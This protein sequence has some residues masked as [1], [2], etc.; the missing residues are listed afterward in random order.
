MIEVELERVAHGGVVVGRFNGKVMFITGGLPGER[1]VVEITEKGNRFDRGRVVRVLD[2]SPG[3]VEPPCPV[4]G[5]CG[6]C[7]W[8]HATPELQL[9]LKTTVVAE[10][11]SRLAGVTWTG[12]V[13]A[14]QPTVN[15]RTRMRYSVSNGR[16]GLRGRRSHEVVPLPETGCLAAAPGPSP[17]QLND[18][19]EGAESL[20]VVHAANGISV[21]ADGKLLSGSPR[22]CEQVG[23][24]SFQVSA[25]GFWQVH[26]GA[27]ETLLDAVL[28]G[29][30]PRPGDLALDLYCGSGLFAA[31]LEQAGAEVFGVELDREAVANARINVP[32]G[33][34][35]ALSLAK[36]LRRLPP[37]V[38]LV[39]LDPP[40]RGAG[41]A[42]VARVV[43]L[44][45]RAIAYVACDPASLARDLA[46]FAVR[47]YETDW[48]RAFDLFPMTHHVECVA[49]LR[50]STRT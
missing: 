13:E 17:V 27:A 4:A 29:L 20:N 33:R 1:V 15:W 24:F 44:T 14:V 3:R 22:V 47:G 48:I 43:D 12:R 40:R 23:K 34:F 2:A 37:G 45:P 50:P 25:S 5:E 36:A 9:D 10:Q 11:L 19:A 18:L 32:R 42:V 30:R 35:L 16:V 28:E 6:G 41:A 21:L 7:D 26:P 38:D 46:G 8:Q 31:G 39:V 49:I